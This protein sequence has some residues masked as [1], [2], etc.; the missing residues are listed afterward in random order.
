MKFCISRLVVVATFRDM[1]V[2]LVNSVMGKV[3]YFL[4]TFLQ[5]KL[6]MHLVVIKTI[7][8][9]ADNF[10]A[11]Q[12]LQTTASRFS[13][14]LQLDQEESFHFGDRINTTLASMVTYTFTL[15]FVSTKTL[16]NFQS[17]KIHVSHEYLIQVLHNHNVFS[18]EIARLYR[19]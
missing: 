14:V 13:N 1:S 15:A 18:T 9:V 17:R 5:D 3:E 2:T 8:I 4:I 16:K 12:R 7:E 6:L 11:C 10:Y 19:F